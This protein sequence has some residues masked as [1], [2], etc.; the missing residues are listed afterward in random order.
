MTAFRLLLHSCLALCIYL[1]HFCGNK[2]YT[3]FSCVS[4]G[5]NNK[6]VSTSQLV[7]YPEDVNEQWDKFKKTLKDLEAKYIP[8]ITIKEERKSNNIPLDSKT[9]EVIKEKHR[10][11]STYVNTK[12][13]TDYSL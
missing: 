11:W 1:V 7:K 5:I 4:L 10:R 12:R 13:E 3:R 8:E 9:V 6:S 2:C